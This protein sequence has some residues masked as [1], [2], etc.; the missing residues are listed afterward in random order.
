MH[1]SPVLRAQFLGD[2]FQTAAVAA[3]Q[4]QIAPIRGE[5]TRQLQA[6][7]AAGARHQRRMRFRLVMHGFHPL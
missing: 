2:P 4:H 5:Q 1:G 7:P 3:D 6:N